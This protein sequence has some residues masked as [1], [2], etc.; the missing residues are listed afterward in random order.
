MAEEEHKKMK[1]KK[2]LLAKAIRALQQVVKK[3]SATTNQLFDSNSET[4]TLLFN[5]AQIPEKKKMTPV[6]IPLPHPLYNEKSEV[7]FLSPN[8]Q[9]KYK[10]VLIRQSPIPGVTKVISIE[11]LGKNYKTP[12][13]KRALA[14]SYDL[15]LCDT[16]VVNVMKKLL[17]TVFFDK[18]H[19]V[20]I[21]VRFV[22][23]NPRPNFEKAMKGTPLR[24]PKGSCVGVKFG[25]ISMSEEELVK[26]AIAVIRG[27]LDNIKDNPVMTISVMATDAPALP[28]WR[29]PAPPGGTVNLKKLKSDTSSS[30]A[31]DTG[32]SGASEIEGGSEVEYGELPSDAGETLSTHDSAS[33]VDTSGNISLDSHSELDSE[34]GDGEDVDLSKQ[35]MPLVQGLKGK[36]NKRKAAAVDAPEKSPKQSPKHTPTEPLAAVAA[37]RSDASAMPP[38]PKKMKKGKAAKA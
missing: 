24:L 26:N 1:V 4:M 38:P 18:K 5:L 15:F 28:V 27:A 23:S 22:A 9:K 12:A 20:P 29:R 16:S 14:D 34:A 10:D 8:P 6:M 3:R 21:P 17:G 37:K 7:C 32:V 11:K 36:K 19:K 31:S 13:L 25:R 2:D 30:A 33:D 35:S